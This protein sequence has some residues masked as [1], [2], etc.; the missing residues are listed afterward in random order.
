MGKKLYH[1]DLTLEEQSELS[2]LINK[3]KTSSLKVKRAYILLAV[4]RK[5]DKCWTDEQVSERY[6]TSIRTVE[7]LR[8]RFV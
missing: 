6:N 5:G 1:V 7:N 2:R 8:K 3:G 4:D